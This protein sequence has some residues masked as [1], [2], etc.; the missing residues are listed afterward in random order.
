LRLGKDEYASETKYADLLTI[1]L[2]LLPYPNMTIAF[3]VMIPGWN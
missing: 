1:E 2:E 3:V